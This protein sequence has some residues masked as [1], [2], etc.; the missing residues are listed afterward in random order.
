MVLVRAQLHEQATFPQLTARADVF[1][2]G[3][4]IFEDDV[5]IERQIQAFSQGALAQVA[6]G[7]VHVGGGGFDPTAGLGEFVVVEDQSA[8]VSMF[9]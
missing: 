1:Q 8:L 7:F 6:G 3:D 2:V 4:V 9:I 5:A